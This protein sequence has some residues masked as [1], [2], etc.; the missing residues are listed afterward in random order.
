MWAACGGQYRPRRT[1]RVPGTPA[2]P[3][4]R[5][6][7]AP[8]MDISNQGK[9]LWQ[10]LENFLLDHAEQFDRKLTV[11]TGPSSRT[12]TRPTAVSGYRCAS[13]KSPRSCKTGSRLHRLRTRP[14][15]R[16]HQRRRRPSHDGS[17]ASERPSPTRR[18][19]YLPGTGLRHRPPHW[20]GPGAATSR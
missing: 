17:R 14:E 5:R 16:P 12:P 15:P 3:R 9:Q 7:A 1:D 19:P 18:L 10:G 4:S 6:G 13:G 11:F 8:Q 2:R 20:P